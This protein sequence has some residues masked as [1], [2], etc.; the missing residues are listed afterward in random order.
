MHAFSQAHGLM[1]P[2]YVLPS[3]YPHLPQSPP[4]T[5]QLAQ[6]ELV[7]LGEGHI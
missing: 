6:P 4:I 1:P 5:A 2:L 7:S 3:P